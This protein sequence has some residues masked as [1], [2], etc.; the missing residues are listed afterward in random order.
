MTYNFET[1]NNKIKLSAKY[2]SVI[3]KG[4]LPLE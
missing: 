1:E 4:S 2:E 3:Q